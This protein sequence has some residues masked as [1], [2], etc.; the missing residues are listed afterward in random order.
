MSNQEDHRTFLGFYRMEGG[1][2][3]EKESPAEEE[4]T[5]PMGARTH[6]GPPS[7][8]GIL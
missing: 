2:G 8:P 4:R 6:V 1:V 7:G 3:E 5:E